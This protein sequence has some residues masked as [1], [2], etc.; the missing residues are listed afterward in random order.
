MLSFDLV[1]FRLIQKVHCRHPSRRAFNDKH[2]FYGS[3]QYLFDLRALSSEHNY[4]IMGESMI[5]V[6]PKYSSINNKEYC[7][8]LQKQSEQQINTC[9]HTI[10]ISSPHLSL[11]VDKLH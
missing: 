11:T 1:L 9:T 3:I 10:K 5:Y 8:L 2:L 7:L 4:F 6:E